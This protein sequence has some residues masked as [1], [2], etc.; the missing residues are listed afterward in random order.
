M[1]SNI[2]HVLSREEITKANDH[3]QVRVHVEEWG[4]S[5]ILRTLTAAERDQFES[6]ILKTNVKGQREANLINLR[7]KLLC[8]A[9]VDSE[10]KR[11][12]KDPSELSQRSSVVISRLFT[13]VQRINGMTPKDVEELSGNSEEGQSEDSSL[14]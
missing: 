9:L 7:S 5:V 2:E 8:L 1:T 4:G 3:K 14:D 13:E 6:N 10:G 12:F 11:L